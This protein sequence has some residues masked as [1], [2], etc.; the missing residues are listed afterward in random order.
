MISVPNVAKKIDELFEKYGIDRNQGI[1]DQTKQQNSQFWQEFEKY[2]N[3]ILRIRNSQKK[4]RKF[5]EKTEKVEESGEDQDFLH[6]PKCHYHSDKGFRG[7]NWNGDANGAYH[8]AVKGIWA[9]QQ[10]QKHY[11]ELEEWKKDWKIESLPK[12]Q[13][14][15]L[16][17]REFTLMIEKIKDENGKELFFLCFEKKRR[18]ERSDK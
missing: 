5:N 3:L 9:I 12:T 8:I 17:L 2:F 6:C 13:N 15:N 14:D 7:K 11:R 1:N 4:I 18:K 10:I 16:K